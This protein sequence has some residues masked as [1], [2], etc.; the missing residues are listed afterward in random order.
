MLVVVDKDEISQLLV[1]APMSSLGVDAGIALLCKTCLRVI[2]V[3][4]GIIAGIMLY[5][6]VGWV[7]DHCLGVNY[8]EEMYDK[9][10]GIK[11]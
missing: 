1:I 4:K 5:F 7:G 2:V 3:G 11:V 8:I 10:I 6:Y 9:P